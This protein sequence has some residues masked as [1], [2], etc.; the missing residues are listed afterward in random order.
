MK[1]AFLIFGVVVLSLPVFSRPRQFEVS[2]HFGLLSDKTVSNPYIATTI[3]NP[4]IRV[5][6]ELFKSCIVSLN[7]GYWDNN[8]QS[9]ND[10]RDGGDHTVNNYSDNYI[11][12][13]FHMKDVRSF[14]FVPYIGFSVHSLKT[15]HINPH[16]EDE[17]LNRVERAPYGCFDFG[18]RFAYNLDHSL[19]VHTEIQGSKFLNH[20][21]GI[22]LRIFKT[23]LSIIR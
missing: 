6:Y 23:G 18:L 7:Y 14:R 3:L 5:G 2:Y 1:K 9:E 10:N 4:E 8:V 20:K 22:V 21:N 11:G 15:Y 16:D 17:W 13:I 12:I 19:A